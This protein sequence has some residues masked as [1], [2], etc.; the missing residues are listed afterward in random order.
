MPHGQPHAPAGLL[1]ENP[2]NN[3][4][5]DY[6]TILPFAMRNTLD[7]DELSTDVN[8]EFA[9]PGLIRDVGNAAVRMGQT[10]RGLRNPDPADV[11]F[12]TMEFAPAGLLAGRLAPKGN[13]FGVFA[14]P[15]AETAN[16]GM[17]AIAEDMA[18]KGA[19]RDDILNKTGWFNDVDGK[20]KFEVDDSKAKLAFD[21][22]AVYDRQFWVTANDKI[23]GSAEEVF[24]FP[25]MFALGRGAYPELGD[26][27]ATASFKEA[28]REEGSFGPL[29]AMAKR[30]DELPDLQSA[31]LPSGYHRK[32]MQVEAQRK[33]L[34]RIARDEFVTKNW[35]S[36]DRKLSDREIDSLMDEAERLRTF[37]SALPEGQALSAKGPT[38]ESAT[39]AAMHELQHAV[40]RREGFGRGG[41]LKIAPGRYADHLRNKITENFNGSMVRYD[42]AVIATRQAA[43]D[44]RQLSAVDYVRRM[45]NITQPRQIFNQSQWYEKSGEI[46]R[47]LG[48]PPKRHIDGGRALKKWL[49]DAGE[50]FASRTPRNAMFD[51]YAN[52]NAKELK[53]ALRRAQY[54][55]DKTNTPSFRAA[56][57]AEKEL[58]AHDEAVAIGEVDP[59]DLYK[60][61]SGEVEARN[62]QKR[63][64]LTPE[65][66][67]A[68]PPWQTRDVDEND[69]I[70]SVPGTPPMGLI[71]TE[72]QQNKPAS[73]G[74]FGQYLGGVI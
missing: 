47:E 3:P 55:L 39:S 33:E 59:Y 29:S 60:R 51:I 10:M 37:I 66:R 44:Y 57:R 19:S 2:L 62:V 72:E 22:D 50:W 67:R 36:A 21:E 4:D 73:F 8:P 43:E 48:P 26:I 31:K 34:Q 64:N 68:S 17:L 6:T 56:Q 16:K 25:E 35:T 40:Q 13:T 45:R 24:D 1:S 5:Y 69:I 49:S 32:L 52:K 28:M 20:W 11:F 61:L 15:Q 7:V 54:K 12:D 23:E 74:L 38:P 41:N 18:A 9:V 58:E 63:L 27:R 65:E 42:E 30:F 14:G 70:R 53:N 46:R 71:P